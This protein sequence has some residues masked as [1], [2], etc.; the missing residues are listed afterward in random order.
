MAHIFEGESC[1]KCAKVYD[2]YFLDYMCFSDADW[3]GRQSPI[4]WCMETKFVVTM[5]TISH[6]NLIQ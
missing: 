6:P 4:A 2:L 1:T 3:L 5:S